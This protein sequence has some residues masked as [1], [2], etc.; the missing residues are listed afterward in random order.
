VRPVQLPLSKSLRAAPFSRILLSSLVGTRLLLR[1]VDW[2]EIFCRWIPIK[3]KHKAYIRYRCQ[4]MRISKGMIHGFHS[5]C[6]PSFLPVLPY[7]MVV[8]RS[9]LHASIIRTF[10][11]DSFDS[12]ELAV[13]SSSPHTVVHSL[14]TA[15]QR[16]S[17][18]VLC[19]H[20]VLRGSTNLSQ[21]AP[22]GVLLELC[23]NI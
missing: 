16:R 23:L 20:T 12:L 19:I 2:C 3:H 4:H 6:R 5:G 10:F 15:T 18:P 9:K 7:R 11:C 1:F 14:Q 22:C 17:V 21:H 8:R 13:I